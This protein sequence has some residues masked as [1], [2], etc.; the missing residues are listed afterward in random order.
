LN[1][2]VFFQFSVL[3]LSGDGVQG[4]NIFHQVIKERL[5]LDA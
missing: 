5:L 1:A 4:L 2:G 3:Q